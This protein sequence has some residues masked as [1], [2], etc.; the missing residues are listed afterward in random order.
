MLYIYFYK[1]EYLVGYLKFT[2]EILH[3]H[4]FYF[5]KLQSI[6]K[7]TLKHWHLQCTKPITLY[8]SLIL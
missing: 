8:L 1:E 6:K 3:N 2:V 5:E 7:D 4:F